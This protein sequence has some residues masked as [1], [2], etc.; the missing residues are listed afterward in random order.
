MAA[1]TTVRISQTLEQIKEEFQRKMQEALEPARRRLDEIARERADLDR[2]EAKLLAYLGEKTEKAPRRRITRRVTSVHKKEVLAK[3]VREGH[4]KNGTEM[5][6]SLRTA[7]ADEGIGS[8]DFRKL[9]EYL[10]NG[11]TAK[12]NGARGTAA[13]TVFYQN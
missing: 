4:I 9:N 13:K 3:F 2:E 10:P 7:L 5:T 11:W 6:K 8:N 12:S 1:D